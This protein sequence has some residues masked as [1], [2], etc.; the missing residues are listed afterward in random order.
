[1]KKIITIVFSIIL[2]IGAFYGMKIYTES[3]ENNSK[4]LVE[5]NKEDNYSDNIEN[6]TDEVD[7]NKEEE[8]KKSEVENRD[9][10]E[11]I[12]NAKEKVEYSEITNFALVDL[13]GNEIALSDYKGKKIFVNFWATWCPPCRGEMPDMNKLHSELEGSDFI[14]LAVNVGEDK[15]TVE[16]FIKNSDFNFKVLLDI[17]TRVAAQYGISAFPTSILI[18]ENGEVLKAVR[19]AMTYEQMKE[20]IK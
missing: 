6:N 13:E 9:K 1:M 2:V 5:G 12:E 10:E 11:K 3:Y 19:G 20:F 7:K 8:I 14:I 15:D 17:D 4:E 18:D 16:R